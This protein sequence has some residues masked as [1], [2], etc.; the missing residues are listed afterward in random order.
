MLNSIAVVGGGTMGT[1]I[2]YVSALAGYPVTVVE[3]NSDAEKRMVSTLRR[4]ADNAVL[5]GRIN[6]RKADELLAR[7]SR[8]ESVDEL[9]R[10]I[11]LVI[12]TVPERLGLKLD[13]LSKISKRSPSLIA[14][15]TSALPIGELSN[16]VQTLNVFGMHF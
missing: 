8:L 14:S 1:G 10:G 9:D 11:D 3:A 2:A 7:I 13:I 5:R 4:T 12:E 6:Q 16:S 15:N